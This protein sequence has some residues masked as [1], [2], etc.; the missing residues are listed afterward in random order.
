MIIWW[1]DKVPQATIDKLHAFYSSSPNG[2]LGTPYPK[3]GKK[4]ALTAW[5]SP[6][7][8]TGQGRIAICSAYNE[9]ASRRSATRS[10]AKAPSASR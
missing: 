3:L 8:G 10:A 7:G 4:I 2:M 6:Q 5:T 9:K 1:G